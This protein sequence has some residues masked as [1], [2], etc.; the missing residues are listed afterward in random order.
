MHN[1]VA[2]L[3][4]FALLVL[5]LLM[6]LFVGAGA[7]AGE[8]AA[9]DLPPL[10][11]PWQSWV[12][13]DHR[14][15]ECTR[16]ARDLSQRICLWPG[17]LT[18]SVGARGGSFTQQVLVEAPGWHALPGDDSLWPQNLQVDGRRASALPREGR[19]T[20][21]LERGEHELRGSFD[22][23][24][25]PQSLAIPPQSAL[26]DLVVGGET[27]AQINVEQGRLWLR[28]PADAA[29]AAA[30][31]DSVKVEVFRRIDDALPVTV[32]TLVRL[33]V[34]GKARELRLGRMLQPTMEPLDFN[35][36]LPARLEDDGSLRVQARAGIWEVTLRSRLLEDQ[37]EFRFERADEQWPA[38]EVWCF[39]ANAALRRVRVDGAP[40]VDPSQLDLPRLCSGASVYLL[41]V[42]TTL[43]LEQVTRGDSAPPPDELTLNRTVWLDFEGGGATLKD[44]VSG[45][46]QRGHR[47][48][49]EPALQLGRVKVGGEPQL[50]TRVGKDGLAGV[51]LGSGSVQLE[52]IS[53]VDAVDQLGAS[54]WQADFDSADLKLQL[55]PGWMLWHAGGPDRV[56]DSWVSQWSLWAIFLSLLVVAALFRLLDARWAAV[57]AAAVALVYHDELTLVLLLLPLLTL[58]ALLR[59]VERPKVRFWLQ[60]VG[61]GFGGLL[62]LAIL[63]FA[64]TQ[65]RI[66][67]YPQ[68]AMP[69]YMVSSAKFASS[70]APAEVAMEVMADSAAEMKRY[71]LQKSVAA[72]PP[73]RP[74]PRY[75]PT[76]NVQTG[77][78]EPGWN[79][80]AVSMSWSGPVK[81]EQPLSLYLTGPWLTRL[82]HFLK[83]VLIVALAAALLRALVGSRK[84]DGGSMVTSAAP[85]LMLLLLGFG[86]TTPQPAQA[87]PEA[88][89][90]TPQQ[91]TLGLPAQ[92]AEP[93]PELL[94]Q[95]EERLLRE[96][97]A[98]R[99]R[100]PACAPTCTAIESAQVS[101]RDNV[102]RLDLRVAVG[103]DL[104]VALP[105]I[106]NWQP[107]ALLVDEFPQR[108][109]AIGTGG[110][111]LLPLPRGSRALVMEGPL[112]GDDV[113]LQFPQR[114]YRIAVAA[115]GWEV[116]GVNG[117]RLAAN[118]LQLQRQQRS[119][120]RETLLPAP[121]KPFVLVRRDLDIDLDWRVTTTVTRVAPQSGAI[122]LTLPLLPGESI[123]SG[124]VDSVDGQVRVS[125]GSQDRSFSWQSTLAPQELLTLTAPQTTQWVESWRLR[126]SWRWLVDNKLGDN[127]GLVPVRSDD[128]GWQQWRPWPGESLALRFSRP[129]AAAGVT[130]TVEKVQLRLRPG[131]RSSALSAE[132]QINS[133]LGGDY[134]LQLSEPAQVKRVQLGSEEL[135][136]VG[137]DARVV[138]PLVPG[139][140]RVSVEWELARGVS[141]LMETPQLQLA[142]DASNIDIEVEMPGD[143][144]PLWISGPRLGP[145]MLY[146]GVLV[147]LIGVALLLGAVS[148]RLKLSIPLRSLHWLLLFI[149]VSTI[150]TFAALPVL[151]WFFALEARHRF[152]PPRDGRYYL[153]QVGIAFLSLVAL[154]TLIRVIP[155]SLLSQ[156]DMQ[157]TGN[158]SHNYFYSWYQ[159]RAGRELPQALVVSLPLWCYRI[160]M[161]VWSLWLAFALLRWLR[162]GW[163]CFAEGG[164]WPQGLSGVGKPAPV[165]VSPQPA[166][167][168]EVATPSD[169]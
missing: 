4:R 158:G 24:E 167:V 86:V 48:Q 121:I 148:R 11:Q 101:V 125:L 35:A 20:L 159:D 45:E 16:L 147:V 53:R 140:N 57:G 143:R 38:Q 65:I 131:A 110:E 144:W 126:S 73:P 156:P 62:V 31:S 88:G 87:Q 41:D 61:Y 67:I 63:A 93:S 136:Q 66:A 77:P 127:E 150:N 104:A 44:R 122:N 36:P 60:R 54:G 33:S 56:S 51:A 162:W 98:Q 90:S 152:P 40:S 157:V 102:L 107:R 39:A 32:T 103:A 95:L 151:L 55:P 120:T 137:S 58:L 37:R 70:P 111:L 71:T 30:A 146:W 12:L 109:V 18:V 106:G 138:L 15:P 42:D 115:N 1:P 161:L 160:A 118:S 133:S 142:G 10:L 130:T 5:A 79:W 3:C 78:G 75:Q 19:P 149:G 100:N 81:A 22:W 135:T 117:D 6:P 13:Y 141:T 59:V 84:S 28:A 2:P 34:S 153:V 165:P 26:V 50:V 80:R 29:T 123:V 43:K 21:W 168:E 94:R 83:V 23:R 169:N 92:V 128:A 9:I 47:L 8:T 89:G 132:L 139:I 52:A 164:V 85:L 96:R 27:A 124:D 163:D 129:Q 108:G 76:D 99:N 116:F 74:T 46:V 112:H 113:T 64:V 49:V 119:E 68:L 145:A 69:A 72:P 25:M 154:L 114:P 17:R 7:R 134:P 97:E 155:E 14:E 105:T 166:A 82:I 91:I